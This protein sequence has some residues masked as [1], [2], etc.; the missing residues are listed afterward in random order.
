[1][2]ALLPPSGGNVSLQKSE[3]NLKPKISCREGEGNGKM[4]KSENLLSDLSD[5]YVSR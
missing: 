5:F 2:A 4:K 3:E 1:V